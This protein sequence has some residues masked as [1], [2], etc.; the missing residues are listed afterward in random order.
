[1]TVRVRPEAGAHYSTTTTWSTDDHSHRCGGNRR[2]RPCR[3]PGA[4]LPMTRRTPANARP[5]ITTLSAEHAVRSLGSYAAA[6]VHLRCSTKTLSARI[7]RAFA[8]AHVRAKNDAQ[9]AAFAAKRVRRPQPTADQVRAAVAAQGSVRRACTVLKI[10][11]A[12]FYRV[13]TQDEARQLTGHVAFAQP[14]PDAITRAIEATHTF[15]AAA[16]LLGV[17]RETMDRLRRTVQTGARCE[18]ARPITSRAIP[19]Q[20]DGCLCPT[21]TSD[22]GTTTAG[23]TIRRDGT[24]RAMMEAVRGL[25]EEV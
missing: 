2:D 4:G 7:S 15:K 16:A 9:S 11:T 24:C 17:S 23:V 22:Y 13:I 21:S 25:I 18:A 14:T 12:T 20:C 19:G 8:A 3:A 1:V 5:D 6:A 10:A